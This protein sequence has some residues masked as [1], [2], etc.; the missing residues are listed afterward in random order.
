MRRAHA[1]AARR[2]L[3]D[4]WKQSGG[5]KGST[6]LTSNRF[7]TIYRRFRRKYGPV[8]RPAATILRCT[9]WTAGTHAHDVCV[10]VH[11]R[12]VHV[13]GSKVSLKY[14]RYTEVDEQDQDIAGPVVYFI[15]H[16]QVLKAKPTRG[17]SRPA[18][19]TLPPRLALPCLALPPDPSALASPRR[20]AP[21][22]AS[23]PPPTFVP[24]YQKPRSYL[25][26]HAKIKTA[27]HV[28]LNTSILGQ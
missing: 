28:G 6:I 17:T 11:G 7:E 13:A 27:I 18:T 12:R 4:T 3:F 25:A 19:P 16:K 2:A 24:C 9:A 15:S 14:Q 5:V 20:P 8:C 21:R 26:T 10:R 22:L 1:H 23:A